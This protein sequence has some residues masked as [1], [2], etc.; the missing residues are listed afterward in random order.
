MRSHSQELLLGSSV[1]GG[2]HSAWVRRLKLKDGIRSCF[3]AKFWHHKHT[4][5]DVNLASKNGVRATVVLFVS[6]LASANH[7]HWAC[8]ALP[9]LRTKRALYQEQTSIVA[10]NQFCAWR[11]L[12][13]VSLGEAFGR[14]DLASIVETLLL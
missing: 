11:W 2:V 12:A 5:D 10:A 6:R 9:M 7:G 8:C 4:G 14:L 1:R 3:W 13:S